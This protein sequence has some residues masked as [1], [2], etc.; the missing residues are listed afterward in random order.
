MPEQ[1]RMGHAAHRDKPSCSSA[2]PHT[3]ALA[4]HESFEQISAL[5]NVFPARRRD[6]HDLLRRVYKGSVC[7]RGRP[8]R[9]HSSDLS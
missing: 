7:V 2:L 6:R 8:S 4:P 9:L 5:V 1:H 3:I